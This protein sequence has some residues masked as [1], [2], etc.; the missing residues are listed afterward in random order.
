M[1]FL[2]WLLGLNDVTSIESIEVYLSAPWAD[3]RLFWV[4]F[5]VAAMFIG[6]IVFYRRF[7]VR[8]SSLARTLLGLRPPVPIDRF[9]VSICK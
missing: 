1:K 2:G 6:A 8:G 3:Q 7:Q 5:G 4:C 9:A